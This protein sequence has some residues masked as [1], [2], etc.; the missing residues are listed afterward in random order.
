VIIVSTERGAASFMKQL[1]ARYREPFVMLCS[2]LM[3]MH[4]TSAQDK[5]TL[6]PSQ[7]VAPAFVIADSGIKPSGVGKNWSDWYRLRVGNAPEGYTLWRVEFWLTG[8]RSCGNKS[9]CREIVGSDK[10][11]LW[12]FRF[13]GD[14][15]GAV[16]SEGHIRVTYRPVSR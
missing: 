9:E 15:K 6:P 12:E 4:L 7:D 1:C 8:D 11:I 3:A 14:D 16:H 13:Q 10:E 5:K 2:L